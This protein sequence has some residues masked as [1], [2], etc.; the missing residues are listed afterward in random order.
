MEDFIDDSPLLSAS[1]IFGTGNFKGIDVTSESDK[2]T[3]SP[4]KK[5][6]LN[7]PVA[8]SLDTVSP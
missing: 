5:Q 2:A 7:K 3:N 4:L 1:S 6:T 8:N